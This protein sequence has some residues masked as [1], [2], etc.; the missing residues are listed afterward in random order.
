MKGHS[1]AV[2]QYEKLAAGLMLALQDYEA[3]AD[4][5]ARRAALLPHARL[6]GLP[7]IAPS[8]APARP[9]LAAPPGGARAP[10]LTSPLPPRAV[11]FV[12]V[13]SVR[14]RLRAS[15]RE[16]VTINQDTGTVR[17]AYAPLSA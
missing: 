3:P 4:D 12:H 10:L 11:V 13:R 15:T 17:T 14:S 6:L 9:A 5:W 7:T 16:L 1:G 8:L 2:M